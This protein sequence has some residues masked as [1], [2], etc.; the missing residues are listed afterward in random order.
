MA[1]KIFIF[2]RSFFGELGWQITVS[3]KEWATTPCRQNLS[4]GRAKT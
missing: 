4:C 1:S 3:A 2:S